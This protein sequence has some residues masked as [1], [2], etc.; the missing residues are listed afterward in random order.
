MN[1]KVIVAKLVS[2][3]NELDEMGLYNEANTLTKVAQ[4]AGNKFMEGLRGIGEG[5]RGIGEGTYRGITGLGRDIGRGLDSAYET[6]KQGFSDAGELLE[7]MGSEAGY[8]LGAD[9]REFE[10]GY[11]NISDQRINSQIEALKDLVRQKNKRAV[12]QKAEDINALIEEKINIIQKSPGAQTTSAKNQVVSLRAKQ[13]EVRKL[14]D[15]FKPGSGAD[16]G[17]R[18]NVG[19]FGVPTA[20][21]VAFISNRAKGNNKT[22]AQIYE[23]ALQE[24]DENFA[25]NVAKYLERQ[26]YTRDM[27]VK[28]YG[29]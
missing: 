14:R 8:N 1:K 28:P 2:I 27:I 13:F 23:M 15:S 5:A 29:R 9:Q 12:S 16:I 21:L 10:M 17:A 19:Q 26:G 7:N 18:A 24:R 20:E 11:A 25:N 22:K 6:T 3:A 4:A